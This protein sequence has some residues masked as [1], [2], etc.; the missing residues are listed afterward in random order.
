MTSEASGHVIDEITVKMLRSWVFWVQRRN[1]H[2]SGA[3]HR[4]QSSWRQELPD[5]AICNVLTRAARKD[6]W[7]Y[8]MW[9]ARRCLR[10]AF[11][12]DYAHTDDDAGSLT[13]SMECKCVFGS[14]PH[15]SGPWQVDVARLGIASKRDHPVRA[16]NP[17]HGSSRHDALISQR[18][19]TP[20]LTGS[21]EK[22][23]IVDDSDVP[24]WI[25]HS[26]LNHTG[27][28]GPETWMA[29]GK[30]FTKESRRRYMTGDE[31]L[32]ETEPIKGGSVWSPYSTY[33]RTFNIEYGTHRKA[34]QQPSPS[35]DEIIMT[36]AVI[37]IEQAPRSRL[38]SRTSQ[39]VGYTRKLPAF[40]DNAGTKLIECMATHYS[41]NDQYRS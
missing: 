22:N 8:G 21:I 5:L 1:S 14:G 13:P 26:V 35:S 2:A 16:S 36:G 4:F 23:R 32:A 40:E 3:I 31:T 6:K 10:K 9:Q 7:I 19:D 28:V 41:Y 30:G 33:S 24:S 11:V 34:V 39:N 27:D 17:S 20:W 37:G 25:L 12:F 15:P 29:I 18:A 38:A